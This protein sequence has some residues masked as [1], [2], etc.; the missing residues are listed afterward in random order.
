V[1][2]H[3]PGSRCAILLALISTIV[4]DLAPAADPVPRIA[5]VG[6]VDPTS[7]STGFSGVTAFWTRLRELGWIEG[8]NLIAERR[9]ADGRIDRLPAIMT[10]IAG[11]NVDVIVT[12]GTPSAIAAKNATGTIPIVVASM[13]DPIGS[14]IV[15]SLAHPGGN[16]T[17]LSLGWADVGG[18]WLQL[19]QEIVPRLSTVAVIADP[20]S[21]MSQAVV[22]EL[23]EIA[24]TRGMKVR[25][26]PVHDPEALD[27]VFKQARREAQAILVPADPL[28]LQH[29]A[30]I[31]L[32]AAR[33]RLPAIY[34]FL[35][36]MDSG[37]LIAY[38]VD[39]AV[40]FRRAADYVDKILRGIR[41]ADLPIEQ[42]SQWVLAVNLTRA[43]ALGLTIPKSILLRAEKV[44]Q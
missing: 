13:G 16:L 44:I 6:Y 33:Y 10:E 19:L 9:W 11:R 17:G 5:R 2:P 25:F 21:P 24:P 43:R 20:T 34:P 41:P 8:K 15:T 39:S 28:T 3:R 35:E 29:R 30:K 12:Y 18:K 38:G 22:E 7:P 32:L 40:L 27:R 36:F 23:E 31:T 1:R 4:V 14:G 37:G 26:L 42:P